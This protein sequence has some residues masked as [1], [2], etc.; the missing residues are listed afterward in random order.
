MKIVD[1]AGSRTHGAS[2]I[3]VRSIENVEELPVKNRAIDPLLE[4][5]PRDPFGQDF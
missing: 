1:G 3:G 2:G 4:A 5:G